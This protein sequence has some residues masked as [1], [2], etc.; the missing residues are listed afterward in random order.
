[1]VAAG[2][3]AQERSAVHWAASPE[4]S[5]SPP[6][7]RPSLGASTV[8]RVCSRVSAESEESAPAVSVEPAE[9]EHQG[10]S[11]LSPA[12]RPADEAAWSAVQQPVVAL[13]AGAASATV[14]ADRT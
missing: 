7:A 12:A 1:V 14:A 6:V 11:P 9:P 4:V 5:G 8:A 10:S 13:A 2:L 3:E